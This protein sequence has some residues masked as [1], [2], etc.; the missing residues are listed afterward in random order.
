M[1]EDLPYEED[2]QQNAYSLKS[3]LRY[4][5]HKK[6]SMMNRASFNAVFQ[7]GRV[8]KQ[9]VFTLKHPKLANA[10]ISIYERALLC[11]P[12]SYRLW[13]AYLDYRVELSEVLGLERSFDDL[14]NLYERALV[15]CYKVST[16]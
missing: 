5:D 6:H 10:L 16:F 14:N 8:D 1:E 13:K 12:G 4:L 2:L 7:K 9:E 11:L 3:W 15:F